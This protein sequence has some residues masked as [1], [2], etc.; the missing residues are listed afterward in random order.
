MRIF[1]DADRAEIDEEINKLRQEVKISRYINYALSFILFAV[2]FIMVKGT[3]SSNNKAVISAIE[4]VKSSSTEST[5][6]ISMTEYNHLVD[7]MQAIQTT[8]S[9]LSNRME[10][11]EGKLNEYSANLVSDY[12]SSQALGIEVEPEFVENT[13]V[14]SSN[15]P[16]YYHNGVIDS[17]GYVYKDYFESVVNYYNMVPDNIRDAFLNDGWHIMV[18]TSSIHVDGI[19]DTVVA[20]TMFQEKMIYV[21]TI[22]A[23]SIIHEM[24]HYLDGKNDFM[25]LDLD[26]RTYA[27]DLNGFM[28]LDGATH[29]H[30]YSTTPEY[31]AEC[32]Y[33]YVTRPDDLKAYCPGTYDFIVSGINNV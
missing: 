28:Q 13:E 22:D 12:V 15:D 17:D 16:L 24:G 7:D 29:V 2:L 4:E 21:S 19:E 10:S 8:V 25:S 26:S 6:Y 31:F 5:D 20:V 14:Q 23:E 3:I 18:T 32:F 11:Y 1:G 33:L 30:N 27:K 9:S